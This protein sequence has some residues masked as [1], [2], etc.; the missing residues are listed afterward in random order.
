MFKIFTVNQHV[1][2]IGF[3]NNAWF[4]GSERQDPASQHR[5]RSPGK[6][7]LR[8]LQNSPDCAVKKIRCSS[9]GPALY[10]LR[11]KI[12]RRKHRNLKGEKI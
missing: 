5:E 2:I 10:R 12:E 11:T 7:F 9:D 6:T 4:V 3:L 8:A 1:E